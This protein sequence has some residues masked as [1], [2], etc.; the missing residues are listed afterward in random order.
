MSRSLGEAEL[1]S[2]W[3]VPNAESAELLD[4]AICHLSGRFKTPKFAAHVT[5]LGD[6]PFTPLETL[7]VCRTAFASVGPVEAAATHL[8]RTEN[9]FMSVF[10]DVQLSPDL[11]ARRSSIFETLLSEDEP[12]FRPH[13]SLAYGLPLSVEFDTDTHYFIDLLVGQRFVFDRVSIVR[14]AKC[15]PISDW[16]PLAG[17]SLNNSR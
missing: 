12:P 10:L 16:L 2:I 11:A 13:V 1:H 5:L 7:S 8:S 4:E 17:I 6:L 15:I 3:L 14:S 9:H